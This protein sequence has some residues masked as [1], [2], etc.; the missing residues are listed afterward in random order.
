VVEALYREE[1]TGTPRFQVLR[2]LGQGG[3]G[4]VYEAYDR[5]HGVRVALKLLRRLEPNALL[6]FKNEFRQL[7]DIVHPNLVT[8]GELFEIQGKWF[9]TMEFVEG[10][11]LLTYVRA[12]NEPDSTRE[13]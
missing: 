9:F 4:V 8:L 3:A 12:A 6:R 5:E 10:T 7:E 2:R 11:D 1:F 13:D